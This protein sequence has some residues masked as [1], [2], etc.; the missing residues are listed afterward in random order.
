MISRSFLRWVGVIA[1]SALLFGCSRQEQS[2]S[3]EA[4]SRTQGAVALEDLGAA[5]TW[6]LQSPD[7]QPVRFADL[8]GKV[9]VVDF[10]A[11]W[12][13][14]C[15]K[16]IPGYVDLQEKYRDRGLVIVGISLDQQGPGVVRTFMERNKINYPIAMGDQDVV[17][18]F[19]G[20]EGI[21]TTF[22]IDREGRIR[23]RKVGAMEQSEYEPII[24]SLL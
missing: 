20:V 22:L 8:K 7:G 14:P 18:A 11:T 13:P 17:D 3:A 12:C 9:V 19:G 4:G 16:E 23:H 10:W 2:A 15:I 21:P 24:S 1:A 6:E 5:P